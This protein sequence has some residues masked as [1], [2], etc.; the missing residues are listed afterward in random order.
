[1]TLAEARTQ[2]DPPTEP[3]D[4]ATAPVEPVE[5]EEEYEEYEPEVTDTRMG[6]GF[7]VI[8]CCSVDRCTSL[9]SDCWGNSILYFRIHHPERRTHCAA[10]RSPEGTAIICP[11]GL[12][13][14]NKPVGCS[15]RCTAGSARCRRSP[16]GSAWRAGS[17]GRGSARCRQRWWCRTG[18]TGRTTPGS[19][20]AQPVQAVPAQGQAAPA[21][22]APQ[23][24]PQQAAPAAPA[25]PAPAASAPMPSADLLLQ[26]TIAAA[27][28]WCS[29]R[30][31]S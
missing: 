16:A 31:V 25:A 6:K 19:A 17:G 3:T 30:R 23:A 2:E 15:S 1:M 29:W 10:R 20:Q 26:T 14:S 27:P 24:A 9:S 21:A 22:A 7:G 4:E 18:A 13:G 8:A 5:A 11:S 12:C 28:A